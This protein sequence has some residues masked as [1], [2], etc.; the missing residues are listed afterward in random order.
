MQTGTHI[1]REQISLAV[2]GKLVNVDAADVGLTLSDWLRQ[3][4]RLTG[5]KVVCAE[6]DCGACSVLC[7][8]AHA[9]LPFTYRAI[10]SCIQFMYQLDGTH[11]I[12]VEGL[13][14]DDG[15]HPV[16]QAMVKHFG[17][18]CGFC[19]PGFVSTLTA[20]AHSH[21]TTKTQLDECVVKR[22][23]TG[24]LC[25]CTGYQQIIE[26]A[27]SLDLQSLPPLSELYDENSI[28]QMLQ[29]CR[30]SATVAGEEYTTWLPVS[31][32][33]AI[34]LKKMKPAA[35]LV[36][37]ATDL[38]VQHNKQKLAAGD[39]ILLSRVPELQTVAITDT[40]II[41]GAGVNWHDV[42][43]AIAKDFPCFDELLDLFGSPQIR[44]AGTFGGNLMNA[45]PIADSIPFLMVTDA[46][47]EV[48]GP[49]GTR[50]IL[51]EQFYTGYKQ[52]S[53]AE[54][55][56]LVRVR[57]PRTHSG[58]DIQLLKVSQRRDMD[59]ST[60]TCALRLK[61]NGN[62]IEE[63]RV[64]FGGVGPIV[65]RLSGTE[66]LLCNKPM[67]QELF[68]QAGVQAATEVKPLSDVRGSSTYRLQLVKNALP[69]CAYN[70]FAKRNSITIAH[71]STAVGTAGLRN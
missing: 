40:E 17:S 23:L 22:E 27:C 6:G 41:I 43:S 69:R 54:D 51:I 47:L 66:A 2:N 3:R 30:D 1:V 11:V 35:V 70:L 21:A 9:G 15:L 12:T 28:V 34:E 42:R 65:H 71:T 45:S 53:L 59:I 4:I 62:H 8:Y 38:G 60:V 16:Q 33:E 57:I 32:Q 7:A 24:N 26:A 36:A 58:D 68:E 5:T 63:A 49:A 25:R 46:V 61:L 48:A 52:T 20:V 14:V 56:I 19:T 50:S 44:N 31:L 55:E 39:R 37:G 10:D 13:S 29:A 18:Q 67:T 64:A